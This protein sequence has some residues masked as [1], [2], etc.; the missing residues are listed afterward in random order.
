MNSTVVWIIVTVIF[1]MLV[2]GAIFFSQGRANRVT[3]DAWASIRSEMQNKGRE[4]NERRT[5]ML[6]NN[7]RR[8]SSPDHIAYRESLAR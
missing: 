1:M 8:Y 4:A 7:A 5:R 3:E 2:I 6:A